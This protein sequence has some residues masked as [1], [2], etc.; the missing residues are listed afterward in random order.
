MTDAVA[1][2][3]HRR[4]C[5]V[6]TIWYFPG[7]YVAFDLLAGKG[8][9][10][11]QEG[12]RSPIRSGMTKV[13]MVRMTET[14]MVRMTET[15]KVRMTKVVKPGLTGLLLQWQRRYRLHACE[16]FETCSTYHI[17]NQRLC[18][19][20]SMVCNDYCLITIFF[21]QL[22]E[23]PVPQFP[24]GHLYAHT[25]LCRIAG[26][27]ETDAMH[28]HTILLSPLGHKRLVSVTFLTTKMKIAMRD[29]EAIR[30]EAT[31]P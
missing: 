24:G 6:F 20:I 21:A 29:G 17:Q 5:T 14:V 8:Q 7:E 25:I 19:V 27:I 11:A 26:C 9:E 13:V 10:G 22:P 3:F 31:E 30:A 18:I 23:P 1:T 15:V 16:A 28:T 12:D 4:V 2:I